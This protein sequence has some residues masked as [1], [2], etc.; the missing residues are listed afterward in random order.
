MKLKIIATAFT[1]TAATLMG[2]AA[3]QA[4]DVEYRGDSRAAAICQAVVEDNPKEL[5]VQLRKAARENR[6]VMF[7]PAVAKHY[8][9]NGEGLEDFARSQGARDTIAYLGGEHSDKTVAQ[10]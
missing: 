7:T 3:A 2:A 6:N 5:K 10:N 9:C 1:L 8:Q 4:H